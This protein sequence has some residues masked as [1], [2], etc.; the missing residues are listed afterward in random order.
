MGFGN[1]KVD[2]WEE[3]K[4]FSFGHHGAGEGDFQGLGGFTVR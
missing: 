1:G 4:E 3:W 2:V